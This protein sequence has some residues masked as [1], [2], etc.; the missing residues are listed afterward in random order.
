[1]LGGSITDKCIV[2]ICILEQNLVLLQSDPS[3]HNRF[4]GELHEKLFT[5]LP[6]H[7]L[8][9]FALICSIMVNVICL[10]E[11]NNDCLAWLY[12]SEH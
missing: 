7:A 2:Y 5:V 3:S 4:I 9:N 10:M 6:R 8:H 1:M 12:V 11:H